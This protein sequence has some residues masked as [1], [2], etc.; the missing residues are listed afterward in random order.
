MLMEKLGNRND[1]LVWSEK[2]ESGFE[3]SESGPGSNV[4]EL[5][6]FNKTDPH[7]SEEADSISECWNKTFLSFSH[8]YKK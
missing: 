4:S 3:T 5:L 8:K 7:N 2:N 1:L 6:C